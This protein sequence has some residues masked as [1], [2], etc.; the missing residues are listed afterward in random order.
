[1]RKFAD[2]DT[3][4]KT[5]PGARG[6]LLC[7]ILPWGCGDLQL[8]ADQVPTEIVI[9]P[10]TGLLTVGETRKLEL[11]VKDQN[12]DP[13]QVP[14]W[15][16]RTWDVADWRIA[17]IGQ[18]GT[19]TGRRGGMATVTA[20]VADL[21]TE[22]RFGM[23]PER[24]LLTAPM[25]YLTQSAQNR[26][27]SLRLIAGRPAL[28]RVF[29]LTDQP[30][31]GF[32]PAVRFT[33]L[34]GSDVVFERLI[35][36]NMDHIPTSLDESHLTRSYNAEVPGS[37]IQ[38]GIRMVVE[39]DPDGV[40]P[41]AP[42]SRTRYPETGSAEVVV[43]EPQMFRQVF[44]PTLF[45]QLPDP[46]VYDWLEGIGPDSY[47]MRYTRHLLPVSEMEVE[48]RDTFHTTS[49][50]FYQ[51]INVIRV[52]HVQEGRRGYYYGVS[53]RI[54]GGIANFGVP[55]S[56]GSADARVYTHELGHNMNL[57][58]ANCGGAVGQDPEYP[59]PVGSIG[60]WGYNVETGELRN[61]A[62]YKDIMSYCAPQIWISDF[63][64]RLA[65]THRLNGDG[66]VDLDGKPSPN[67]GKMLVV[68]GSVLDGELTLDPA[69]VVD[70]PAE[71]PGA[72]GPYQVEG[73]GAG[74]ET[75][76]SLSFTPT[77]LEHGG[78][79]FVYFVP[80]DSGWTDDLD[81]MVLDGPEG[82][83]TMTRDGESE[84][85][86]LTDPATG[87]IQAIIRNWDGGPLPG[88]ATAEVTITRGIPAG[89]LR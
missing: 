87:L 67:R 16:S 49:G 8:E 13:M 40:V 4:L 55:W 36:P 60:V 58:H 12:G 41:L 25:I 42:E 17:Q 7:A 66:G 68:W 78:G 28:L 15:A 47:Q 23:N 26:H 6:L 3:I 80:Y 52:L 59:Y 30:N 27:G 32:R 5:F 50:S 45:D 57:F 46:A 20:R 73:L 61:P 83:Y 70:A 54:G 24:L 22:A 81:R 65:T 77:P 39:V 89:G 76:F 53:G 29:L 63:Q 69:F 88:E 86:V 74:G 82:E 33:L 38:P 18:D 21:T 34:Q 84:M 35:P 48:V 62:T 11:V 10:D 43:V 19:L 85:A 14:V 71:L 56:V 1:M 51:W 31:W 79:T 9:I 75:L 44:V 37:V 72:D 2:I 64:F